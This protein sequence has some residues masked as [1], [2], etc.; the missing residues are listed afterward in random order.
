MII[1]ENLLNKSAKIKYIYHI[2][3]IHIRRYEKHNEYEYIF[4]KLYE[5]FNKVKN[6]NSI[7][8]LTGDLLHNKDNLTPDCVM[9]TWNF[10][11]ELQTIMPLFLITGNHDFVETNNHVKDS[12]EAILNDKNIDNKNIYYLRNSGAYRYGNI[13]FGVSSLIDKQFTY[14]KDI[15]SEA[16]YK[17]GLYHGGVGKTE[18]SVGF[19]LNGDK[20]VSDFDGYNY[21]LLGDIHKYQ[22]VA[23]NM[24]YSSSLISQNFGETDDYHGVLVWDLEKG[25]QKYH[26]IKNKYR[27][28]EIT[29]KD[30]K[31]YKEN[32][33]IN[34]KEFD[35]PKNGRLRI[36]IDDDIYYE[37]IKKYL[38]KNYKKLS[39]YESGVVK[40]IFEDENMNTED[41]SYLTLLEKYI[42]KLSE[43]NKNKCREIFSKNIVESELSVEK[44]LL[45]WK[46]LDLEF[47]NLFSYGENNFIDFTKLQN[48]EITGLFAPNSYGK[49]TIIDILLLCLY[50]DFSR[51]VYSKHRTI[52]SYVINYKYKNFEIKL[53]FI[54]GGYSYVIHK[55]GHKVKK[56]DTKTGFKIIFDINKLYRYEEG[57][58]TDLTGKDRFET[59]E[60]LK[61][62]IGTYEEFCLTTLY[63][64][65]NEKNF[66]DMKPQDRKNFLYNLLHLHKFEYM[67]KKFKAKSRENKILLKNILSQL[68]DEDNIEE[69]KD[70]NIDYEN[71]ISL[72]EKDNNQLEFKIEEL[73][74]K[75]EIKLTNIDNSLLD[76]KCKYY[77]DI[78]LM[79]NKAKF[80]ESLIPD[81]KDY[82]YDFNDFK[83]TLLERIY[84][85]ESKIVKIDGEYMKDTILNLETELNKTNDFLKNKDNIINNYNIYQTNKIKYDKL[86]F[87]L[88]LIDKNIKSNEINTK[89]KICM[90]RKCILDKLIN[91][92]EEIINEIKRY[93]INE[94]DE[95]NY[96][97]LKSKESD[98][99]KLINGI[100][101]IKNDYYNNERILLKKMIDQIDFLHNIKIKNNDFLINT[102]N[103]YNESIK[104]NQNKN[105][106]E[107]V[108]KLKILIEDLNKKLLENKNK[109]TEYKLKISN[110][111]FTINNYNKNI[112]LKLN[113][114]NEIKIYDTLAKSVCIHGI[115][116]IILN[117]YLEGI[118]NYMN[119][120]ISPFINKTVELVLDGN[121][122]YIN[123]YN[124]NDEIINILGGMEHFIVNISLKI[125]LGKLSVLP[126]CGLLIID[127]GVSVLD[128]EHI[129]KF[130]IIAKFLKTNYKNVIIIS[131]IDGIKDFIAHF[132]TINKHS[133][134]DS[135]IYFY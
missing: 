24:A 77:E 85:L 3:D 54:I 83:N 102:L 70:K 20:L 104:Y 58:E 94:E 120:L 59:L 51:N 15:I 44:S 43:Q 62:I 53:R 127:E 35:F 22:H 1:I 31:V 119:N 80:I 130:H 55:K 72:Y 90:K 41:V 34:Y 18:T 134:N 126:K 135:H 96:N 6:E 26:I 27:F 2:S 103:D 81:I 92:R 65:S 40:M 64:Q 107:D 97:L 112:Q 16:E 98:R 60:V 125:T 111:N 9:K 21:V 37:E 118:Q 52:P 68:S 7:I 75:K 114:E 49:S 25:K 4:E 71:E 91:E 57:V 42:T 10:L 5:Y 133:N 110:N 67:T 33:E 79:K 29:V 45:E 73:R 50:E 30:H 32:Q 129:E 66:Y 48:N 116:S 86:K 122:L 28:M 39:L 74:N 84:I 23:D 88:D 113:Y 100:N 93:N 11:N 19:K 63:L 128:K 69:L 89:C 109:I 99:N 115:P 13:C 95:T 38:R 106:I 36:N 82:K 78:N 47:S 56:K 105:N 123:V 131:H 108:K 61:N 121:Y 117:K 124:E 76:L 101:I 12:I 132:I 17:I 8:V 87:K 46:L 14:A